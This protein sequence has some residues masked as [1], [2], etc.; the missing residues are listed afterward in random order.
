[1]KTCQSCGKEIKPREEIVMVRYGFLSK[2]NRF[3]IS[4]DGVTDYFHK[5]CDKAF[6]EKNPG[7]LV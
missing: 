6:R 1:M 4:N 5:G 3:Y 2:S 7:V